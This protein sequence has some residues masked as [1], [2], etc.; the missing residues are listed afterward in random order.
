MPRRFPLAAKCTPHANRIE[1]PSTA[2]G[3][4]LVTDANNH[5]KVNCDPHAGSNGEQRQTAYPASNATTARQ[6]FYLTIGYTRQANPRFAHLR[7]RQRQQ[8]SEAIARGRVVEIVE[9]FM[10]LRGWVDKA[11][12]VFLKQ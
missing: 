2:G 10:S 11:G 7:R 3:R 4:V 9:R 8:L 5:H 12:E 1:Q 6:L